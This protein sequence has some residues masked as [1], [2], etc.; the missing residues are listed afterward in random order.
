[1]AE[2]QAEISAIEA[3]TAME[4]QEGPSTP[5]ELEF[6][7]DDGTMYVWNAELRKY[8]PAGSDAAATA[9]GGGAPSG[10]APTDYDLQAMTF[11]AEEEVLPTLAAAKAAVAAAAAAAAGEEELDD[12]AREKA[13]RKVRG[14]IGCCCRARGHRHKLQSDLRMALETLT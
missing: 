9:A 8:V 6:E 5:D 13:E 11:V 10:P 2:F 4:D 12:K 3:A 1:M 7:D 14:G